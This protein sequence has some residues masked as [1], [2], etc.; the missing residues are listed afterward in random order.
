MKEIVSNC[1]MLFVV[2]Q[3]G[4]SSAT[5]VDVL[6]EIFL[7]LE[8]LCLLDL[9]MLCMPLFQVPNSMTGVFRMSLRHTEKEET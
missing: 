3:K 4:I 2:F 9:I 1:L 7:D 6:R 5:H 8:Q